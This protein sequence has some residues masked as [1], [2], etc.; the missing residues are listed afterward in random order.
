MD[1]PLRI[2]VDAMGGD[3]GPS[4]TVPAA[5][6]SLALHA[7]LEIVLVGREADIRHQL[8]F[9]PA[10]GRQRLS[11]RHSDQVVEMSDKP[12]FALRNKKNS[13]MRLAIDLLKARE[14]SACVSA[15]N[16]GALMAIGCYVLKTSPGIDRPAIGIALPTREGH[17]YLLDLG[18]NVDSCS[19]QLHQF[20]LMGSH[21]S[22]ALDSVARPRVALLNIG[23]EE[24]KGN[25]QVKLAAR[26]VGGDTQLNYVGYIEADRIFDGDCDVIVCDGFVGNVAL[27]AAEGTAR[28]ITYKGRRLIQQSRFAHFLFLLAR[29]ALQRVLHEVNPEVY[30]GAFFLG[31]QGVL[32][33]SH[34]GASSDAFHRAIEKA[35]V[36]VENR[37]VQHLDH[38]LA[39]SYR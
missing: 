18:A 36:A 24:T 28:L 31:L 4:A 25:E 7:G 11:V 37:M 30:N 26:L 17:S 34:G 22:R 23:E 20:A 13:S 33:K 15:G 14:V 38:S 27:K 16:T 9:L 19:E 12:T 29:P 2:A 1:S 5:L 10:Q 6:R 32:V 21:L 3:I 35:I 8:S 39:M